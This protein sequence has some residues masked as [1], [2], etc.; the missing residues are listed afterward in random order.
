MNQEGEGG[1]EILTV[2]P[3]GP[4]DEA[5]LQAGEVIQGVDGVAV[6]AENRTEPHLF[7]SGRGGRRSDS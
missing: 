6:T 2:T 4:A 7:D 5:G 3:G 1:L